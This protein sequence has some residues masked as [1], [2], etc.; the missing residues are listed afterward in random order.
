MAKKIS[1][2]I[3]QRA[4]L[5]TLTLSAWGNRKKADITQ[6][7]VDADKQQLSLSKRLIQSE[8]YDN[9]R[10]AQRELKAWCMAR[11][12]PSFLKD[13]IYVVLLTEIESFEKKLQEVSKDLRDNIVPA[14]CSKYEAQV[15]ASKSTLRELF[16]ESDY[17]SA[18]AMQ[19]RFGVSWNWISF[20]VP[21]NLPEGIRAQEVEKLQ[22]KF[23]EAQE[24]ILATLRAQYQQL[25][26]HA[27]DKLTPE[28][29]KKVVIKDALIGNFQEFFETFEAKNL[30]EDDELEE[31]V[32]KAK[33]LLKNVTGD[34]LR[35]D[36][37]LKT[38]IAASF[39]KV[40]KQI[41]KLVVDAPSRKFNLDED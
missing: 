19:N 15:E 21:E 32:E 9:V 4:T 28:A 36:T 39:T 31:L 26:Q 5:F 23:K 10:R 27:L 37:K 3:L 12:M 40:K 6:I 1:K 22:N 33:E 16:N 14:F 34:G 17:I 29:G 38:Q 13:G 11:C 35:K 18:S 25:I 2:D 30:M 7:S 41:D 24:E 8:E 20:A